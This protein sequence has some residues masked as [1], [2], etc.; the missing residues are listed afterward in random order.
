ME[1]LGRLLI[2]ALA[3][4]F[5][6]PSSLGAPNPVAPVIQL[7]G[8]APFDTQLQERLRAASRAGSAPRTTHFNADRSPAYINRLV[9]ESSPYLQQHAYNPVNWY[10]WGEEAFTAAQRENR[11]IFLSIGYSTCHWCHVMEQ[12]CFENEALAQLLNERFIAIKVDREERPDIDTLYVEAVSRMTGGAGWPLSVFLTPD[13]QPFYGGTYFPPDQFRK[14]L[15]TLADAWQTKHSDVLQASAQLTATLQAPAAEGM[16]ADLNADTLRSAFEHMARSFDAT[17]GGFGRAPKFPQAHM[18]QFLLRY[19]Q[20]TGEPQARHMA[21]VT[22]DHMARGGIHDQLG[23]GFHRYSTDAEW[24]LPHFEKMLYDQAIDARAYLEAYQATADPQ[25]ADVARDIF[26]YV[27]RDLTAPDG[28]FYAAEDADS[29]GEE[30]RFYLWS[31]EDV[32]AVL[33]TQRGSLIADFYGLNAAHARAPLRIP[34]SI[35][36]FAKQHGLEVAGFQRTLAAANQALLAARCPRARPL[37]DEKIIAAWNGLMISSLAYGSTVLG[38]PQYAAAAARAADFILTHMQRDGR[39]VRSFRNGPAPT[40]AY[41]DDY[42]SLVLGLGDLYAATFDVRWL[43]QAA[44]LSDEL[45]RRFTGPSGGL[46]Y[47][48]SDNERLIANVDDAYDGALPSAQ[49]IAALALLRVGRLLMNEAVESGGRAVLSANASDVAQAP[50]AHTEMLVALDFALG[51]TRE[52]VIAGE[53]DANATRTLLAVVRRHYLPRAVL[54]LHPP[55]DGVVET[56]MPFLQQQTMLNGKPAA[57]VCE[58]YVCKLP[59]TDPKKLEELLATR[60]P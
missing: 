42:A 12:Q 1:P 49:S 35:D 57:Y 39:L 25:D 48:G 44:H 27:L 38:D 34:V 5:I 16:T 33:G 22:L 3:V 47:S 17:N 52:I 32:L 51:P 11:P 15:T 19:W 24:K 10:P 7:P 26:A 56:L 4:L 41:L 13:R 54:A 21:A 20:R 53:V 23:G 40:P 50:Q 55:N 46:R 6:V 37:R 43:R 18:L 9:F 60:S 8:A 2:A 31:R 14:V 45:L 28:G 36:A 29:E 59:T 58:R 30:G